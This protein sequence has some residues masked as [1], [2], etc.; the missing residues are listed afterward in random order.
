MPAAAPPAQA[1]TGSGPRPPSAQC[2]DGAGL[3]GQGIWLCSG[4]QL[5]DPLH[6]ALT[7]QRP[8]TAP[9]APAEPA[10]IEARSAAGPHTG[11]HDSAG[12]GLES[13]FGQRGVLDELG[14]GPELAMLL[15]GARDM[16]GLA[17]GQL[18]GAV[19]GWRRLGSWAAAMEH[20]AVAELAGRRIGEAR[21]AGAS[22]DDADRYAAAE[23]G[24]ALTLTR[25]SAE[26]LV[27]R[28]LALAELPATR[29]GLAAGAIDV[30]RALVLVTGTAGLAGD[31]A[32]Q[33]E[34]QV[35]PAA[36]GQTTGELRAEVSRAVIAADPGAAAR[37]QAAAQKSARVEQW[38]EPSGTAALA[39][40]DLP[41]ADALAAGNRLTALA[42]ALRADGAA[43]GMDLLRAQV[44]LAL[45]LGRPA[46]APAQPAAPEPGPGAGPAENTE[47]TGHDAGTA[48]DDGSGGH[49]SPAP[50]GGLAGRPGPLTRVLAGPAGPQAPV[51]GGSVNLTVP[52]QALQGLSG[53]PSEVAGFGPV[54][55]ATASQILAMSGPRLRWCITVVDAQGRAAGH[56]CAARVAV[57][58]GGGWQITVTVRALAEGGCGHDTQAGGYRPPP[59]LRHLIQVRHRRCVFP[60]C[61]RPASQCDLD[62][63]IP[64][65]QGGRTCACNLAPLCRFHHLIKHALGWR[66]DQPHPGELVWT[67]PAGWTYTVQPGAHPI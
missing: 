56:G 20:A 35:L 52:L 47:N 21:A 22:V 57:A 18:T 1:I 44:F 16:A 4:E 26:S 28:A 32:R 54:T 50:A 34:A 36:A 53:Q 60:G 40:R 3:A 62:H 51:F 46:A 33:V 59:R 55:A 65:N 2:H 43:G 64:F 41:P 15:P 63:T 48:R 11:C 5:P 67:S 38:A 9:A 58:P 25:C 30:P 45:L 39:G 6:A 23:V 27:G 13:G 42:A 17:D 31:L 49:R 14:P 19:R 10:R 8:W 66:L 61:R 29:A 37:R 7:G 12:P 24:A